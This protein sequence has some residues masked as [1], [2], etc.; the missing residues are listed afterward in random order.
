MARNKK[1]EIICPKCLCQHKEHDWVIS[2]DPNPE[3]VK[4]DNDSELPVIDIRNA[5]EEAKKMII[6]SH[7]CP[8]CGN[9]I[10]KD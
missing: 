5:M 4:F 7:I 2:I 9:K 6:V 8:T 3:Y 1:M 10:R